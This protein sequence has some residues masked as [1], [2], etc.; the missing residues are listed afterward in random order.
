MRKE[1][2]SRL[3]LQGSLLEVE[4]LTADDQEYFRQTLFDELS[5]KP[6]KLKIKR[7]EEFNVITVIREKNE[8]V[9][10]PFSV[11]D[12]YED[13]KGNIWIG[14]TDGEIVSIQKALSGEMTWRLYTEADGIDQGDSPYILQTRSR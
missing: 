2:R 9:Y 7:N 14:L 4:I 5:E 11:W 10:R 12:V 6:V 1:S 8:G 3:N 13:R